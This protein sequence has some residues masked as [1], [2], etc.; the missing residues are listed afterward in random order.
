MGKSTLLN[1]MVGVRLSSVSP[2][3]HT[4]RRRLL[5]VTLRANSQLLFVDTPGITSSP[6]AKGGNVVARKSPGS[7]VQD[8]KGLRRQKLAEQVMS[9]LAWNEAVMADLIVLVTD[10]W[11][12]DARNRDW[13]QRV[14]EGIS[15]HKLAP[16]LVINKIDL[17]R[18]ERL[19]ELSRR[20]NQLVPFSHTFMIS[21]RSGDGVE[22]LMGILAMALPRGPWLYPKEQL[23]DLSERELAAD[24][25]REKLFLQLRDELPYAAVVETEQWQEFSN[26]SVKISQVICVE[27]EGQKAIVLGAGGVRVKSIGKASRQ[28]LEARLGR[29]VHLKLFVK[30]NSVRVRELELCR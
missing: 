8:Y 5:G 7:V 19:L 13:T 2:R 3:P 12:L 25:T 17:V 18:R 27:R 14:V 1:R 29:Q 9:E 16:I 20:L 30:V 28:D 6:S 26:G 10:I 22:D 23:T 15:V 24:V 11:A 4:T 21:A